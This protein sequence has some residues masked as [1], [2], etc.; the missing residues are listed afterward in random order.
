MKGN[1][2]FTSR[3][4]N[5]MTRTFTIE[6]N[7]PND[8]DYLPNMICVFKVVDYKVSNAMVVPVNTIQKNE[9]E[10]FVMVSELKEGK[11]IAVKKLVSVGKIYND[12]AEIISGLQPGDKLIV[13]GYSDLNNN[14]FITE[15]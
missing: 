8:K 5:Q 1:I 11:N 13:A 4:I 10:T 12:K 6:S 15:Q 9:T 7:I 3:V 2:S 14:E